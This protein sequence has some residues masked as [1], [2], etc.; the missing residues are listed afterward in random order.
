MGEDEK[1]R[2]KEYQRNY[3]AAKKKKKLLNF[4]F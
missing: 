2:L 1:N 3:E 4:L